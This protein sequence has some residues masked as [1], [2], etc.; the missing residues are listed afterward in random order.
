MAADS[1]TAA[2]LGAA[3]EVCYCLRH[4]G[5]QRGCKEPCCHEMQCDSAAVAVIVASCCC[6]DSCNDGQ[7]PVSADIHQP[8]EPGN[9]AKV[10]GLFKKCT[11]SL[12]C[13]WR[14]VLVVSC[15]SAVRSYTTGG[16][17]SIDYSCNTDSDIGCAPHSKV[18]E[19]R[20]G[21]PRS[22]CTAQACTCSLLGRIKTAC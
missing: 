10:E 14:S 11:I 8:A 13:F 7:S 3:V 19:I 15:N 17:S 6:G 4:V 16:S 12:F 2:E 18:H 9:P 21:Q 5:A 22:A 1:A 20:A